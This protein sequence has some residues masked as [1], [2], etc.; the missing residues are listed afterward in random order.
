MIFS[1]TEGST[2]PLRDPQAV[3][4]GL[5]SCLI[6][7]IILNRVEDRIHIDAFNPFC[8]MLT[9][10]KHFFTLFSAGASRCQLQETPSILDTGHCSSNPSVRR[11]FSLPQ[12]PQSGDAQASQL[13]VFSSRAAIFFREEVN[14][15][16][17]ESMLDIVSE[18]I[19]RNLFVRSRWLVSQDFVRTMIWRISFS[20]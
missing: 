9:I 13:S 5:F 10:V 18:S 12:S 20:E 8:Q 11:Q 4:P 6:I 7:E 17:S 1:G 19:F 15:S 3:P 14:S 16:N 2:F